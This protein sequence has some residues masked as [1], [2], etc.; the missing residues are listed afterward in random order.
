MEDIRTKNSMILQKCKDGRKNEISGSMSRPSENYLPVAGSVPSASR[1]RP[2]LFDLSVFRSS[3]I[4]LYNRASASHSK[5]RACNDVTYGLA[6]TG[7]KVNG[8]RLAHGEVRGFQGLAGVGHCEVAGDREM[9]GGRVEC[10]YFVEP[11]R[12]RGSFG[13][14]IRGW[15]RPLW[16]GSRLMVTRQ[17]IHPS[18]CNF[19]HIIFTLSNPPFSWGFITQN[20]FPEILC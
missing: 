13:L 3:V 20:N 5:Q 9:G 2:Y 19:Y 16:G 7:I 6:A 1:R 11:E 18:L 14:F 12:L 17:P 4:Q 15:P 10:P 8:G